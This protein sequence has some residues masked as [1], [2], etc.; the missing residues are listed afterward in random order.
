MKAFF[1]SFLF[2]FLF[3]FGGDFFFLGASGLLST[4]LGCEPACLAADF[5]VH[6]SH[7]DDCDGID[8]VFSGV[9][10]DA[11]SGAAHGQSDGGV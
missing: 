11:A 9:G 1:F 6:A 3:F 8:F 5:L 2:F 7:H 10:S 4:N